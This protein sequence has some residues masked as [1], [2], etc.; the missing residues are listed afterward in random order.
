MDFCLEKEL[1]DEISVKDYKD[2]LKYKTNN[3]CDVYVPSKKNILDTIS[4][5]KE[6][7]SLEYIILRVLLE[8]GCRVTELKQ[9]FEY[10]DETMVNTDEEVIA[11]PL[12]YIR[13]NKQ[14]YFLF[15][16]K[17]TFDLVL[18]NKDELSKKNMAGVK[19]FIKRNNLVPMKYFRK[20]MFTLMINEGI[21]FE[22]ANFIQGRISKNVGVNY[23]LAK[24]QT[25]T[26]QYKRIDFSSYR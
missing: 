25:A 11:Y 16:T 24:K 6:I 12:G 26:N 2:K 1:I 7:Y 19:T 14:S 3:N 9:F 13:G 8:T 21:D 20:F 17:E 5:I 15:M 22:I 4:K 23:Y 10:F 18:Q